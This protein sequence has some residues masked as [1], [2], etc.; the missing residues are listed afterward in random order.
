MK[1]NFISGDTYSI[2]S[3][4]SRKSEDKTDTAY[5]YDSVDDNNLSEEVHNNN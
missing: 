1:I 2:N 3:E 5:N 4:I